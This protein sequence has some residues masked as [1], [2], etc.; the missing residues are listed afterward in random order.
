[1]FIFSGYRVYGNFSFEKDPQISRLQE[2]TDTFS[3]IS[4]QKNTRDSLLFYFEMEDFY[5]GD[6]TTDWRLDIWQD[7][8]DDLGNKDLIFKGIRL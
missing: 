5:S 3:G 2:I 4:E 6:P 1:M 7:V 8:F